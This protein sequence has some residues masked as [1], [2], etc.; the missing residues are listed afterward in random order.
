[1][2]EEKKVKKI[3]RVDK[4]DYSNLSAF[5]ERP[6]PTDK[7]VASFERVV[8]REARNQEIDTNLSEIY[9]DK[10]GDLVDVKK[11]K[12]KRRQLSIVRFF[13]RLV[14]LTLLAGAAYFAYTY[15]FDRTNDLSALEI[16][17]VAPEKVLAGEEFSYQINY[18]NPSK[19]VLTNVH[20]E[21]QYPENFILTNSSITPNSGNYGWNLPSLEPG[22]NATISITGK[23]I[24]KPDSVNVI[25]ARLSY[26]PLN[27]SSQFKKEAS[28]STVVSGLGWQTDLESSGTAFLNQDNEMT[29]SFS[30]IKNNYLGDFNL[31]FSLPE[32][33]N[34]S[35]AS[36]SNSGAASSSVPTKT[37]TITNPSGVSWQI[38]GLSQELGR[39]EIPL[40]YKI[41]TKIDKP[42]I[43]VRLEKKLEDGQSYIFWE[44]SIQP[45]L[46]TSDLNLTMTINDSKT[47][48]AVNFGQ[49]L[50]YSISYNNKG[51]HSFKDVVVMAVLKSDFLD[52]NSIK[53]TKKGNINGQTIT[54]TKNEIPALEEIKPGQ[55]GEI[56]FSVNLAPF[57]NND[58]GKELSVNSYAQYGVNNQTTKSADNK[59]NVIVSRINSDLSLSEKVL[60]FNEDNTPVGSGSLPPKVGEKSGFKVYWVV[61]NN[62]HELSDTKVVFNLPA[63]VN[64][65]EKNST[66][67]GSLY[68]D[69]NNRQVVWEIGKLPVS[70]YRADAEFGISITPSSSDQ[71]KILVLSP[72]SI[73]SATDRETN[74]VITKKTDA[75]TTKLEDD[76]IANLSNSGRVQ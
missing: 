44:K 31:T 61:K 27:Y 73:I 30:D 70:V 55:E 69:A 56:N 29:L 50:N 12:I 25:S 75:K 62:L 23:L 21:I 37:I 24:N 67:V 32:E 41:R 17:I 76:D 74:N 9:T 38:S 13:K 42:E 45:D 33:T 35:V 64:F 63:N 14:I 15:F 71:N 43:I 59:S 3:L 10:K 66:N 52:F 58:L 65:D 53:M 5:V 16:G 1:M 26:L 19:F 48:E 11:M 36:S 2:S 28:A 68:Y 20:L 8:D 46:V 60:Y 7:E 47:D 54:W 51:S 57:D 22:A 6:V 49:T 18:H 40:S 34:A 4:E 39:Q 72:G